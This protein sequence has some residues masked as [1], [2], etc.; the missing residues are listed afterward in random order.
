MGGRATLRRQSVF[1]RITWIG[2]AVPSRAARGYRRCL[3]P[4]GKGGAQCARARSRNFQNICSCRVTCCI[5]LG[6]QAGLPKR[7]GR[8]VIGRTTNPATR[9]RTR[10]HLIAAAVYS[11]MLDQLSYSRSCVIWLRGDPAAELPAKALHVQRRAS[12]WDLRLESKSLGSSVAGA[13]ELP[14][15]PTSAG[16]LECD[17][18]WAASSFFRAWLHARGVRLHAGATERLARGLPARR[19]DRMPRRTRIA[20]ARHD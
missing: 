20:Q 13:P 2:R 9:S 18:S 17:G 4:R 5:G 16:P 12:E 10:D 7:F 11:Q 3:A 15:A 19:K 14:A 6:S 8:A 1:A